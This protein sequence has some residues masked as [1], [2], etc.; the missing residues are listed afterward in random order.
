LYKYIEN[1]PNGRITEAESKIENDQ[2][3]KMDTSVISN[4]PT[5]KSKM[6]Q[7]QKNKMNQTILKLKNQKFK[8]NPINQRDKSVNLNKSINNN[9]TLS[10]SKSPIK[11]NMKK[12]PTI[13]YKLDLKQLVEQ[14]KKKK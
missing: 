8:N 3:G 9:K 12:V 4:T 5:N 11:I 14:F 2:E 7:V 1:P 10:K 6:S 13:D